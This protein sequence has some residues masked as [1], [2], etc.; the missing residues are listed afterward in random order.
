[1]WVLGISQIKNVH[2]LFVA[3]IKII[4]FR[5]NLVLLHIIPEEINNLSLAYIIREI[6]RKKKIL[7]KN[8]LYRPIIITKSNTGG[9]G[10]VYPVMYAFGR[11][12]TLFVTLQGP[13]MDPENQ[14]ELF[15]DGKSLDKKDRIYIVETDEFPV[16]ARYTIIK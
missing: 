13:G 5:L 6:F 3:K 2:V 4:F 14:M 1:M 8:D 9:V 7:G 11:Q 12:N 16:M 10:I 15:E